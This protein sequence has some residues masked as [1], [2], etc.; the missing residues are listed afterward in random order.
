MKSD[1]LPFDED[2]D[3]MPI[4]TE[5]RCNT[6]KTLITE[7]SLRPEHLLHQCRCGFVCSSCL[8]RSH[9]TLEPLCVNCLQEICTRKQA[10]VLLALASDISYSDIPQSCSMKGVEVRECLESLKAKGWVKEKKIGFGWSINI[11][12]EGLAVAETVKDAYG[13]MRDIE[14]FLARLE[15]GDQ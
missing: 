6:C 15:V 10:K 1:R 13:R 5:S 4:M 7:R 12:D 3:N 2:V 14:K 9:L 11:A 8:I